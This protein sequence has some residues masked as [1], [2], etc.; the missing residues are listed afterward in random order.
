MRRLFSLRWLALAPFALTACVGDRS[1]TSPSSSALTLST[2]SEGRGDFH[3]YAA[4][5]TSI[6][7]GVESDGVYEATQRTSWPAQL[8]A[9]AGRELSLPLIEAPGCQSPLVPRIAD[10]RRLSGEPASGST[11]C[12]PNVDG[13]RLSHGNLAISAALTSDALTKTPET[14]TPADYAGGR[15][16]ARVLEPGHSQVTAML[17]QNPKVV[18]VELGANELLKARSGLFLPGVTVVPYA[19]WEPAYDGVIAAVEQSGAR[20]VV[21][22]GLIDDAASFPAFRFGS[23]LWDARGEFARFYVSVSPDCEG[24]R[25]ML[26]VPVV[27][28]TAVGKGAAAAAAGQPMPVLSCADV[29][30]TVDYVLTP[31]DHAALNAQLRAMSARIRSIA[32]SKGYAYFDLDALYATPGLKAPFS[33]STLMFSPQPYGP[34]V[35]LDGFHPTAAGQTLLANAAARALDDTYGM[36]IRWEAEADAA[37]AA[38]P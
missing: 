4:I 22:V 11:V 26:L 12:A 35:S 3:R 38:A 6:S 20:S 29:P 23:E 14:A 10:N 31:A 8:A 34:L 19:A 13:V 32:E 7:M 2:G 24:S 25:N 17:A 33:V 5:G 27:V 28:P 18:S 15:V 36:G 16:Y 1:P 21:L 9:M 37:L 30:W